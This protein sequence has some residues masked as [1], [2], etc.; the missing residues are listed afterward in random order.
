MFSDDRKK[1]ETLLNILFDDI[2]QEDTRPTILL[3]NSE[4]EKTLWTMFLSNIKQEDTLL[5]M[6][7]NT[8]LQE[9]TQLQVWNKELSELQNSTLE[10]VI[11]EQQASTQL[12][13]ENKLQRSILF[14][15]K[16]SSLWSLCNKSTMQCSRCRPGWVE[17]DARCFFLSQE[18]ERWEHARRMCLGMDGDLAVILSTEDQAFLT[19]LV[20][21]FVTEHPQENFIAA[22]IGLKDIM[23]EGNFVWVDGE[24]IKSDV[25][26]WRAGEPN[27]MLA[28]WDKTKAG[29]DCVG[30]VPPE[31]IGEDWLYNW[32]D[33]LCAGKLPYLCE[34]KALILS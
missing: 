29:Q 27:N 7:L 14:S 16:L 10:N 8:T 17:H 13:A 21:R 12:R 3:N 25:T 28:S 15:D 18:A 20:F 4:P 23:Q 32:D 6:L 11:I 5:N 2:K 9:N 33:I 26:F 30:L 24:G 31:Q 1:E 22:W 19:N 34:T